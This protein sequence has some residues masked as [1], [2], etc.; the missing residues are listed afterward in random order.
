MKIS[1]LG[2]YY[3]FIKKYQEKKNKEKNDKK[4]T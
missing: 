3:K 4:N 1:L 2:K